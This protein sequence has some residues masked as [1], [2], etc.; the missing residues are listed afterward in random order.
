MNTS[1]AETAT[2]R[3]WF[4]LA[5]LALPTLLLS[6][7]VS[8]LYLAL[9]NL[10]RDLGAS[11]TEQLWILDIYSFLLAGFLVTMGT[12]GDR[13][14]R[15]RLLLIGAAA[16]GVASVA[17]AY[18]TSAE[19][20]IASRALLGVAGATLAPSTMALIR[21]MFPDPKQMGQ[22]IAIWFACFMGGM[23]VGPLVGGA[24]LEHFWWGSAFLLGIPVMVL[25]LVL[26]PVVLPEYRDAHAGRLD[27]ASV[28]LSLAAILPVIYGLKSIARDGLHT[29]ALAATAAG[30]AFGV[31]FVRRQRTLE[32]PLLDL[33]LFTNGRFSAALSTMWFGG[34][35]MAGVSLVTS[36]YLQLVEGFSPLTAGLW[37]IP[38]NIAMIAGFQIAPRL[39][40]RF[41]TSSVVAAGLVISA[42]GFVM[43]A[44]VPTEDG[45]TW[46]IGGLALAA[47]GMSLPMALTANI[48]MG[49]TPPEKAG[50]AAA[51]METSGEFG[52]AVGIATLGSL[53]TFVYRGE[54]ADGLPTGLPSDLA[55]AMNESLAVAAT[56][57]QRADLLDLAQDAFTSGLNVV[58][59]VGAAI[60]VTLAAVCLAVLRRADQPAPVEVVAEETEDR[61]PVAATR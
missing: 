45:V 33:R 58:S 38:Q 50:S 34:L 13:I 49:A 25:L 47:A 15:R 42:A 5:I 2:R 12:L 23:T 55:A 6:L 37:L 27:M 3:A 57:T 1:T 11:S 51:V 24:L 26:G 56:A 7:D 46:L 20:L 31:A 59:G 32:H 17:A 48:I 60:F 43:M 53:A 52:I 28:A 39:A 18:A 10:S 41:R 19:M 4:G 21:N 8:V 14:G 35:V 9:P 61:V 30:I 22:A 44:R 36:M 54:V 40:Q 29:T 16:F